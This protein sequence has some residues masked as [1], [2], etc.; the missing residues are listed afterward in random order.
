V[1]PPSSP[2]PSHPALPA[3]HTDGERTDEVV[4]GQPQHDEAR[5]PAQRGG[6]APGER[7]VREVELLE[8]ARVCVR[9]LASHPV[10]GQREHVE[11]RR[12]EQRDG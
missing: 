9:E 11:L 2:P 12:V 1:T 5:Q 8:A 4:V 3:E 7:V 6:E 10:P